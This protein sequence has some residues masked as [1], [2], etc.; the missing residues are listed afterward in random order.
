MQ[1]VLSDISYMHYRVTHAQRR[2]KWERGAMWAQTHL[3]DQ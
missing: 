3:I 1:F 2:T